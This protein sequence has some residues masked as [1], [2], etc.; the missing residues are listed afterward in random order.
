MRYTIHYT[1]G[2]YSGTKDVL[3]DDEEQAKEKVR[4]WARGCM[5]SSLNY[6]KFEV[7]ET[8]ET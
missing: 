8:K 1:V 5:T 6:E 4:T 7:I 3:A 2:F